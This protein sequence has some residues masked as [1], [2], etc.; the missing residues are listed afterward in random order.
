M[1]GKYLYLSPVQNNISKP[2]M[3]IQLWLLLNC[4]S[5]NLS[6][7]FLVVWRCRQLHCDTALV[8]TPTFS[9]KYHYIL[10]TFMIPLGGPTLGQCQSFL[11]FLKTPLALLCPIEL[12]SLTDH[13]GH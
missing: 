5:D 10:Q 6:H 3:Q 11:N 2:V 7:V 9:W 12:D 4:A 8:H 13:L 1:I